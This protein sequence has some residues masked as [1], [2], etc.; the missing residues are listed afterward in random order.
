MGMAAGVHLADLM[1]PQEFRH[2]RVIIGQ[3]AKTAVPQQIGPTIPNMRQSDAITAEE[4]SDESRP[5]SREFRLGLRGAEDFT[6]RAGDRVTQPLGQADR[7]TLQ[8][9]NRA[10]RRLDSQM[11]RNLSGFVAPHTVCND[12]ETEFGHNRIAVFIRLTA[13]A[14]MGAGCRSKQHS[15]LLEPL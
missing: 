2:D 6:I 5:H 3:S 13:H 8:R 15:S 1:T 7:R 12:I 4:H 9:L 10:N 11:A 14:H